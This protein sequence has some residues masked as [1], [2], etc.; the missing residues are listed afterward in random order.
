MATRSVTTS[1]GHNRS[2]GIDDAVRNQPHGLPHQTAAGVIA[3]RYFSQGLRIIGIV[4]GGERD[5]VFQRR[6]MRHSALVFVSWSRCRGRADQ[7][8]IRLGRS[9][10]GI[11]FLSNRNIRRQS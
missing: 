6:S 4:Q 9:G 11:H 1:R 8:S 5:D 2:D 10:R 3:A 7:C